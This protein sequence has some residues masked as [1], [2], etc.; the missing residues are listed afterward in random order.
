M[1]LEDHVPLFGHQ[2]FIFT[3]TTPPRNLRTGAGFGQCGEY[4]LPADSAA[5]AGGSAW[6]WGRLGAEA[7][8]LLPWCSGYGSDALPVTAVCDRDGRL[9]RV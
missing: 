3:P 2:R 9:P 4:R 7:V 5:G 6:A 1:P 8:E